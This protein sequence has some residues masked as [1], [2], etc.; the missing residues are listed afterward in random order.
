MHTGALLFRIVITDTGTR[1]YA[2][3][4]NP[5]SPAVQTATG[6][7][8]NMNSADDTWTHPT[9]SGRRD[10]PAASISDVIEKCTK[11]TKS[12]I[13]MSSRSN[14]TLFDAISIE[15]D[16]Y[17]NIMVSAIHRYFPREWVMQQAGKNRGK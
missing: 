16:E 10:L 17:Q 9:R 14:R 4:D 15:L 8:E 7:M 12:G 5:T 2:M 13:S 6:R 3:F 1:L 11:V